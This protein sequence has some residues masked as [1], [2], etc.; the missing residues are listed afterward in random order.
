MSLTVNAGLRCW[1]LVC[2][3]EV[4]DSV[5]VWRDF[6]QVHRRPGHP[7]GAWTYEGIGPFT[8]DR[9]QYA[10]ALEGLRGGTG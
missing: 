8:F 10:M 5:V 3:I 1:P 7:S 9:R 4:D 2:R 6:E